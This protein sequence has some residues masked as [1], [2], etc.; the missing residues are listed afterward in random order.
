MNEQMM[1]KNKKNSKKG[2]LFL[3]LV[4]VGFIL[5]SILIPEKL[6]LLKLMDL[7]DILKNF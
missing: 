7:K 2:F 3:G 6:N 1:K 5:T 4:I